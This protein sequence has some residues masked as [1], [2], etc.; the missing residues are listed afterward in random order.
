MRNW[1]IRDE[2]GK[3]QADEDYEDAKWVC[4]QIKIPLVEVNFVKEFWN[5]VFWYVYL[6]IFFSN[7]Y[8]IIT[9]FL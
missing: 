2:T 3:C 1:D 7:E 4:N 6:Y 8:F 5:N 9:Y